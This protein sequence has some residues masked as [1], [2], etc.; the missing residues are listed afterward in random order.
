M[1]NILE[2]IPEISAILIIGPP[3]SEKNK[4]LYGLILE[5]LKKEEPI[6]F[7]T[8]DNFPKDIEENLQKN[9]VSYKKYEDSGILKFIDCYSAQ[10][11]NSLTNTNSIKRVSGPLALN[12]I[13]VALSEIESYFY[14]KSKKQIVIFQSLSTM[15]IYSKPEAIERFVQVIIARTKNAG[16]SIFFTIEEGM[17]DSKVIIGLE[18]LMDGI[19]ESKN[20]RI[21]LKMLK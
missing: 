10:I 6:L 15:L 16:G 1:N 18:H 19:I 13:S 12:E 2:K 9:D 8:K 21:D 7:I 5:N 11:Q 17:H 3:T 4:I 14:K 20:N